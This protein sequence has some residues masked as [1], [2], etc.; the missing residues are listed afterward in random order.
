M[1]INDG[2]FT[3][4][5]FIVFIKPVRNNIPIIATAFSSFDRPEDRPYTLLWYTSQV[6]IGYLVM[7]PIIALYD[8]YHM[9]DMLN[10]QILIGVFGDGLAEPI[11]IRFGKHKYT[12]YSIFSLKK[13][14]RTLEGSLTIFITSVIVIFLFQHSF[15]HI[16]FF[17]ALAIIPIA[18]TLAE[19]VS[20]HTW[21][22]PL[23]IIVGSSLIFLIK[24]FF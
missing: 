11:G 15:N 19:A 21:D 2:L 22:D 14:V 4:A 24:K 10:I 20:P 3:L 18:M 1:I 8:H 16:Q 6:I 12:T 13:Y 7:I 23:M 5:T 17:I 9:F